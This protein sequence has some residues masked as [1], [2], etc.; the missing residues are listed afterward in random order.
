MLNF[1]F[2]VDAHYKWSIKDLIILFNINHLIFFKMTTV[3]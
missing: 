2:K 3:R 1:M